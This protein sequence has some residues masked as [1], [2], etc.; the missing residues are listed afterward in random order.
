MKFL[1]ASDSFKGSLSSVR[2]AELL[3]EA[4]EKVFPGCQ[5]ESLPVAD[6]GEGTTEAVIRALSGTLA[7]VEVQD[8]LGRPVLAHFGRLQQ[9]RGILEMASA[10]GLP[11]LKTEERDPLRTSSYG[12][13][14]LIRAALAS[15][16]R[17]LAVAIGGSATNDGGMGCLRA[18][19]VAFLDHE[20]QPL[21]GCGADLEQ[22][23][24][25]DMSG[26]LPLVQE[27]RIT[28]MCDVTNPLTGP[29]GATHTFGRQ[30]GAHPETEER[31]E[32]GME[33]YRQVLLR[34]FGRDPNDIPGAGAAGGLGAGLCLAL[35]AEMRSGIETVLDWVGFDQRLDGVSAVITGEGRTDWQSA[36]GKVVSGVARRCQKRQIP[37]F[38]LSGGFGE[39]AETLYRQG[40]TAMM[41]TVE[42]PIS[43]EQAMEQAEELYRKAAGR[44]FRLLRAGA[45]LRENTVER[46]ND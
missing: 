20:G 11:L 14:Q 12:T 7:A 2:T 36:F 29:Q 10:S 3:A 35:G 46:R 17:D 25:V 37:V 15:G 41:P 8:P 19:G 9:G 5:W 38:V 44:L 13:G 42:G 34:Q 26:L 40:V 21:A 45:I 6:G 43:L 31:L 27:A 16:C 22:V 28:V 4:A 1:F 18:L 39:G 33:R 24:R 30:K 32:R 23:E